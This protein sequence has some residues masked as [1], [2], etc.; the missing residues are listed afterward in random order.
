MHEAGG[1]GR[2]V[3]GME[4]REGGNGTIRRQFL[5]RVIA[6]IGGLIGVGIGAPLVGFGILP[7]LKEEESG[8]ARLCPLAA[9]PTGEPTLVSMTYV[10]SKPWP[11]EPVKHGVYVLKKSETEFVV[12]D[13]RCTHVGCP[14]RWNAKVQKFFSP[15]HGGVFDLDGRVLAGPPP[16]AGSV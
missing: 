8:W 5:Q 9:F 1:V 4:R 16:V 10:S 2:G 12:Y 14:V 7:A 15:C 6:W 3:A 13:I 11:E